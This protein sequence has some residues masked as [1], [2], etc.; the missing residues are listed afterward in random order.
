[1]GLG[2]WKASPAVNDSDVAAQGVAAEW[3]S[4]DGVSGAAG[5][6]W[7]AGFCLPWSP[8]DSRGPF[9][10]FSWGEN[11]PDIFPDPE[12]QKPESK[13]SQSSENI[14]KPQK[15]SCPRDPHPDL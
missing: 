10:L 2:F 3:A 4:Q 9:A 1:M 14:L 15:N 6:G 13:H 7:A 12:N 11:G 8:R 5:T